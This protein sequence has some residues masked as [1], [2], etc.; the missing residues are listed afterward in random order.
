MDAKVTTNPEDNPGT[1]DVA[2]LTAA[3]LAGA[4]RLED[5]QSILCPGG[6]LPSSPQ[7]L[8]LLARIALQTGNV[9]EARNYWQAALR[10]NPAYEPARKALD[11][12]GSPWFALAAAKRIT[13]LAF[14]SIT[15]GLAVVGLLALIRQP[16]QFTAQPQP[17]LVSRTIPIAPRPVAAEPPK[18]PIPA[19]A[20]PASD[21][22]DAVKRLAQSFEL[23]VG[24]LDAQIQ[25]LQ[26]TQASFLAGQEKLAQ[27]TTTLAASNHVIS[28]RIQNLQHT[29]AALLAG[30]EK[31]TQMANSL[32]ASNRILL[33]LQQASLNLAED[34]RRELRTL[35]NAYTSDRQA[36]T[37]STPP[38]ATVPPLTLS[39]DGMTLE[40]DH[41]GWNLHFKS[42]LFD[43]GDHLKIG[44]KSQIESVARALVRTQ[45]RIRV[46]IVGFADNEP[47]TWPWAAPMSD[48]HLGQLRAEKIK[49]ILA[50]TA[51]FP[52]TTLSATN[53]A[54]GNLPYPGD[55]RRNRTVVLRISQ[56]H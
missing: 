14:G 53:G 1:A 43:R 21:A 28:S 37:N 4:G 2:F 52:A 44:S 5:A 40:P 45:V 34:T 3:T 6:Q 26:Q 46:Q 13:L 38:S 15:V 22:A 16:P 30:Q 23:R 42:A 27:L 25:T 11:S 36:R 51:L 19:A 32:A 7:A 31:L 12:L 33:S 20:I 48:A 24:Q 49:A 41:G 54:G 47:P 39:L 35:S 55:S 17:V 56:T 29:Q 18:P 10:A 50:R 8:D 9:A